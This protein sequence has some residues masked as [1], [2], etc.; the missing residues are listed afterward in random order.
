MV[1]GKFEV[2]IDWRQ[3]HEVRSMEQNSMEVGGKLLCT[4]M[5][6]EGALT[7]VFQFF[8]LGY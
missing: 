8:N 7:E 1:L 2:T 3:L 4:V 6:E 5:S